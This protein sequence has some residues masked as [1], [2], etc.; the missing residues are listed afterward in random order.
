MTADGDLIVS[1]QRYRDQRRNIDD[2]LAKLRAMLEAIAE[3]PKRRRKTRPTRAAVAERIQSKQARSR[4]K[5]MRRY[6]DEE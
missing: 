2:A 1:S 4:I 6:K 5:Q 3:P